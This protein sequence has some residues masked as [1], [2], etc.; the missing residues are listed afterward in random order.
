[1][2][3]W[4]EDAKFVSANLG[5]KKARITYVSDLS[6]ALYPFL[7]SPSSC[8]CND[9][10]LQ[11]L[12]YFHLQRVGRQICVLVHVLAELSEIWHTEN[13]LDNSPNTGEVSNSTV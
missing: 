8:C 9:P 4:L 3:R 5:I 7:L 6:G 11:G 2:H 1:M 12:L 13:P 10:P